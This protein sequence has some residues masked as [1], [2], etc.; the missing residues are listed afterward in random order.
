MKIAKMTEEELAH[1]IRARPTHEAEAIGHYQRH[2]N[3]L[4]YAACSRCRTG[5]HWMEQMDKRQD[6][7]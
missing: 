6:S 1:A 2:G 3:A 7:P 4:G 5:L